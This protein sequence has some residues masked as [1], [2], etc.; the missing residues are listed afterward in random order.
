[1]VLFKPDVGRAATGTTD[2][3]GKYTLEY[4]Y[5]VPGTTVG[6]TTVMFEW[7]LGAKD[8]KPLA[9]RYTTKSELK[10]DVQS[11]NNTFDFELKSD[12]NAPKVQKEAD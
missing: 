2:E 11:G 4:T 3:N 7:P 9:Q 10:R 8:T 5:K 6:P 1:M 12:A